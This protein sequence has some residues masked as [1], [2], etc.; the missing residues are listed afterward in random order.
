MDSIESKVKVVFSAVFDV[1][2]DSLPSNFS[3]G[4]YEAW[5]S[6]NQMNIILALE[7]EFCITF[8][9]SEVQD[10][11]SYATVLKIIKEKEQFPECCI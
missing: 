10:M 9:D 6:L 2:I 4:E 3:Y 7:E 1:T 8:S 5:D 11:L